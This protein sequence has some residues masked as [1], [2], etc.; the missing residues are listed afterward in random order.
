[1]QADVVATRQEAFDLTYATSPARTG[2]TVQIETI[3]GIDGVDTGVDSSGDDL[4]FP[5]SMTEGGTGVY[6]VEVR[7]DSSGPY[8]VRISIDGTVEDVLLVRVHANDVADDAQVDVATTIGLV[9]STSPTSVQLTITDSAGSGA[10]ADDNG[11]D[12][13]WPEAMIQVPG[14]TDSWYYEDVTFSEGGT[15]QV[16]IAPTPGSIRTDAFTVY[17]SP[18]SVA[19]AH[20][21][22]WEPTTLL[23]SNQWLTLSYIRRWTGWDVNAIGNENLRELRRMAI[24]TFIGETNIWAPAWV[25]TWYGLKGQGSRLD[26]PVSLL[27]PSDGGSVPSVSY[28]EPY[29]DQTVVDNI[30]NGD[31]IWR[32]RGRHIKQPYIERVHG[33]WW[34]SAYDVKITGTFGLVDHDRKLPTD[35]RQAVV[36]LIR[37]HS[38]SFGVDAD[39][40]RDQATLNRIARESS[41]DMGVMYSESAIGRGI[42]GDVT[43]DRIINKYRVSAGSWVRKCGDAG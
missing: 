31:L 28:Y 7:L 2:S 41:R 3:Y 36:G 10:G 18:A 33:S 14:Y 13:S 40:A 11:D 20:Y 25:G 27:L 16:V 42:T 30:D 26:L 8:W 6:S 34:N 35:I 17:E 43:V 5:L 21:N 22:G 38:L 15:Y 24:D 12:I 32:V 4:V 39:E 37:W 23:E 1:M 19:L 29:G 9:A